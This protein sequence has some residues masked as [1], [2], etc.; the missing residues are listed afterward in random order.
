MLKDLKRRMY[1]E[2][3]EGND[4]YTYTQIGDKS[5]CENYREIRS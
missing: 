5:K 3:L 1:P 2:Q 4:N